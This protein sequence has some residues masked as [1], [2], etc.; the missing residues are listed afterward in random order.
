M[1]T[2]SVCY[3]EELSLHTDFTS[4]M[5][6][7]GLQSMV[8]KDE[9]FSLAPRF[10][11]SF[12][13]IPQTVPGVPKRHFREIKNLIAAFQQPGQGIPVPLLYP[14]TVQRRLKTTSGADAQ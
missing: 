12:I 7:H 1:S 6:A 9:D 8:K 2:A 14:V 10:T 3:T 13:I 4:M 5:E 11:F